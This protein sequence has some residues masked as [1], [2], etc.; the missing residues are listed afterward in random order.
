MEAQPITYEPIGVFCTP[1]RDVE[2][3]PIQPRG[4]RDVEGTITIDPRFREG[5]RDLDGFSH[6]I[7]IYHLHEVRGHRLV[8]TP[9][10][11]TVERGIF[12]TRS[13]RRPNPI[14]LSV[15]ELLS[16]DD[17][18]LRLR[19]VDVLDGTPV[20]DLKPYVPDFDA[21]TAVRTGWVARASRDAGSTR[22]D[23]RF[24]D[25]D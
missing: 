5:L 9:F 16:I 10:L 21:P 18:V 20:L 19:G 13:P 25:G 7:V 12:A 2:G 17:G 8:V 3:M 6:V 4:A 14:G 1:H 11:D 24:R 15:M 22:S 23:G